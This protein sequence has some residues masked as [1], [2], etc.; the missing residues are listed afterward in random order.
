[1]IPPAPV[2]P[3]PT[4]Q[5]LAW[6]EMEQYAFMHFTVNTFTEK[7]GVMGTRTLMFSTRKNSFSGWWILPAKAETIF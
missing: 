3:V 6:Q 5:Q 2:L 7:N 1:V 4:S